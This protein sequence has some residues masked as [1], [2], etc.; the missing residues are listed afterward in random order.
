MC[1]AWERGGPCIW[2]VA[3]Q[4]GTGVQFSVVQGALAGT[5]FA[6]LVCSELLSEGLK[7]LPQQV[8]TVP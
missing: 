2:V 3:V 5:L 4:T 6:Y 1:G 7:K 8:G